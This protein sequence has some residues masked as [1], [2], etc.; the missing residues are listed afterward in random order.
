VN[1]ELNRQITIVI[2]TEVEGI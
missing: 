2:L 1:C